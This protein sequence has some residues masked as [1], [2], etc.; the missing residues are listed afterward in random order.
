MTDCLKFIHIAIKFHQDIPYGYIPSYGT[1]IDSV[2]KK[3]N[4][5]EVTQKLRK[6]EQS[7]LYVTHCLELIHIAIKFHQDIPYGT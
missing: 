6:G 7:F 2:G 4:Q 5:R 3:I 1:R